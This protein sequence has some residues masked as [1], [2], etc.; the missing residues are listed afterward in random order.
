[1]DQP[2]I[3]RV[4]IIEILLILDQFDSTALSHG[5]TAEGENQGA[6]RNLT[7]LMANPRI[8][9]LTITDL[10]H[11]SGRS[12][13]SFKRDFR[14]TFGMS[15]KKWQIE[16]RLEV[17]HHL[18][19][20][21]DSSITDISLQVGY[22]NTSHFVSTYKTRYSRCSLILRTLNVPF[23]RSGYRLKITNS[24]SHLLQTAG[25]TTNSSR[26]LPK[27]P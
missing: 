8:L 9:G 24:T 4:K 26:S 23:T 15:P 18:L 10:A 7:E 14:A 20:E 21:S 19:I 5:L 2:E 16:R 12:L 13:S 25:C 1:M 11:L 17:A 3:V 27:T 22:L 6:R